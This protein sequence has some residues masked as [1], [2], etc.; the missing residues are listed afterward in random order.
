MH[1]PGVELAISRSQV[2][3]PNHRATQQKLNVAA[4]VVNFLR[5]LK[6]RSGRSKVSLGKPFKTA[7]IRLFERPDAVPV[8]QSTASM[9]SAQ[10]CRS[11]SQ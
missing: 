2:R 11:N 5:P 8:I 3:R 7:R 10:S 1:R 6:V 9:H 4:V